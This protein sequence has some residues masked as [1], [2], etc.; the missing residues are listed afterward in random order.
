MGRRD[1]EQEGG[2]E[3]KKVFLN[4]TKIMVGTNVISRDMSSTNFYDR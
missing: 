1:G 3:E 4:Q 2:K